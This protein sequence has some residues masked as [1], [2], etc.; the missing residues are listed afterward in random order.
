[1]YSIRIVMIL[2]AFSC[3]AH[4]HEW[5][6]D[7]TRTDLTENTIS[8]GSVIIKSSTKSV[9]N[10]EG[11]QLFHKSPQ[12]E[13]L[14]SIGTFA[15]TKNQFTVLEDNGGFALAKP[16]SFELKP[17]HQISVWTIQN[18][19]HEIKDVNG[20]TYTSWLLSK[21]VDLGGVSNKTEKYID[22][23][24]GW[25]IYE[26]TLFYLTNRD[27]LLENRLKSTAVP[28]GEWN[29]NWWSE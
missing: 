15:I 14:T 16:I 21:D 18:G 17:N 12:D 25:L 5:V 7:H 9:L 2:L 19:T 6:Y 28:K 1:M 29:P 13:S 8:T 20:K 10:R 4:P 27:F 11:I 26:K 24:T 3:Q 22:T 23:E